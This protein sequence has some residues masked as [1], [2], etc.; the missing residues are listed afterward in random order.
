[1]IYISLFEWS[2]P[3]NIYSDTQHIAGIPKITQRRVGA[4]TR[5]MPTAW[6][7]KLLRR[8]SKVSWFE[9]TLRLKFIVIHQNLECIGRF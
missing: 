3:Q 8:L 9:H 7:V 2:S 6:R 5:R 4:K 1:M